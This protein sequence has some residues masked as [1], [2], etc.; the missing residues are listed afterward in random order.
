MTVQTTFPTLSVGSSVRI[1]S[2][3]AGSS[4][5][6]VVSGVELFAAR[7]LETLSLPFLLMNRR[8]CQVVPY[9]DLDCAWI[10]VR[11]WMALLRYQIW[12]ESLLVSS[13]AVRLGSCLFRLER[14]SYI[15][16]FGHGISLF[17]TPCSGADQAWPCWRKYHRPHTN[18]RLATKR[19]AILT[20]LTL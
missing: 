5:P 18:V 1:I 8:M 3:I 12:T 4:L 9:L 11:P 2:S 7:L 10:L 19:Y 17:H 15:A 14:G 13:S 6:F 16:I 20:I